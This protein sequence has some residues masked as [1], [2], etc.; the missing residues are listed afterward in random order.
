MTTKISSI[1][2][3]AAKDRQRKM[4]ALCPVETVSEWQGT[5]KRLQCLMH[6]FPQSLLINFVLRPPTCLCLVR[7]KKM[8]LK[9]REGMSYGL[10]N[11]P[12]IKM[13]MKLDTV[14]L[15]VLKNLVGVIMK[16]FSTI[17]KRL[18]K[19]EEIHWLQVPLAGKDRCL[20][21]SSKKGGKSTN[22]LMCSQP[23]VSPL[24]DHAESPHG[25]YFYTSYGQEGDGEQPAWIFTKAKSCLTTLNVI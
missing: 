3:A 9:S 24:E 12:Q 20:Y 2:T 17:F 10:P 5:W 23:H 11:E 4:W 8:L 15:K 14:Y 19:L 22:E 18:W 16:T 1:D 25:S 7:E 13:S 21:P 6:P